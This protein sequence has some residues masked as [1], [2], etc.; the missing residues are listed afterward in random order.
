MEISD[1]GT[2]ILH[3]GVP[4]VLVGLVLGGGGLV[5]VLGH[6]PLEGLPI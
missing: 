5:I 3:D 2:H 4:G 6:G 1:G